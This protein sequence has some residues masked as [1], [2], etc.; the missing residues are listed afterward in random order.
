MLAA[1]FIKNAMKIIQIAGTNGKGSVATYAAALMQSAGMRTGLF[2][3]PHIVRKEERI[4]INGECIPEREMDA[5]FEKAEGNYFT[6]LT[7]AAMKWF[8]ENGVQCAVLEVGLGGKKDPT[9][10][11]PADVNVITRIGIDHAEILGDTIEKIAEEKCGIIRKGGFVVTQEQRRGAMRIIERTCAMRSA[12]LHVVT[13]RDAEELGVELRALGSSQPINAAMAMTAVELAGLKPQPGCLSRVRIPARLEYDR[14]RDILI[15]GGHNADAIE[16]LTQCL[17]EKFAERDIVLLT[18]G[19][20]GKNVSSLAEYAKKRGAKVFASAVK[21][22]R[23]RSA[24]ETARIFG[25]EYAEDESSKA[26]QMAEKAAKSSGALLV[27][28]GSF[29]LAGELEELAG[30]EIK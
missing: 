19:M 6:K 4:R 3:S 20:H 5:L 2:T 17:D 26:F 22:E 24:G 14:E 12:E 30:F 8:A 27:I 10:L 28:A 18:A 16:E 29:Y 23:S 7:H 25:A 15:D 13:K 1:L 9:N 11:Y 21:N